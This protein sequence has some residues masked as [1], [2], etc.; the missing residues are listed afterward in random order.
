MEYCW[1]G[2]ITSIVAGAQTK[3]KA[4]AQLHPGM[5]DAADAV[6]VHV[7]PREQRREPGRCQEAQR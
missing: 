1:G 2:K 4:A 3:F 7:S 5:L 6:K